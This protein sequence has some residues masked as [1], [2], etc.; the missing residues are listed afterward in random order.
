[1]NNQSKREFIQ[2]V[3]VVDFSYSFIIKHKNNSINSLLNS[4]NDYAKNK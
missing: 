3:E 4:K 2:L 1:M